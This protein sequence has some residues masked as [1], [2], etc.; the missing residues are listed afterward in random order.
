M[1]VRLNHVAVD[2]WQATYQLEV[3]V[4]QLTFLGDVKPF[5]SKGFQFA[6]T[7]FEVQEVHEKEVV[8]RKDGAKFSAFHF[9]F[10]LGSTVSEGAYPF[11]I[12]F[13]DGS[14]AL[15][16][17]YLSVVEDPAQ[18]SNA[19]FTFES[20]EEENIFVNGESNRTWSPVNEF[21]VAYVYFGS[22]IPRGRESLKMLSD[23]T[24]PTWLKKLSDK[25]L[26]EIFSFYEAEFSQKPKVFVITRT[27]DL[28]NKETSRLNGS[29]YPGWILLNAA[30]ADWKK[31]TREFRNR[32]VSL[33]AHEAMHRFQG[34][35]AGDFVQ[36]AWLIEGTAEFF[37]NQAL[38]KLGY[39]NRQEMLAELSDAANKCVIILGN[40]QM[41]LNKPSEGESFYGTY[42]CG[43]VL[44]YA[45]HR[46]LLSNT[47]EGLFSLWRKM[48]AYANDHNGNVDES[49]YFKVLNDFSVPP[50]YLELARR[51]ISTQ[52]EKPVDA[53][54]D[55][56]RAGGVK[57][58]LR[59]PKGKDEYYPQF[60]IL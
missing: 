39:S 33:V 56:L 4:T 9:N 50:N 36:R 7:D 11:S 52:H 26:P 37:K 38:A 14:A 19:V 41:T 32:F 8:K 3:P 47:A 46:R 40:N 58:K 54:A 16:T 31:P 18:S 30:G 21:D 5:R 35:P 48:L 59:K 17:G 22:L 10:K 27:Y 6:D 24:V 42:V 23:P 28:E 49:D 57:F 51:F 25:V 12:V 29:A 44:H 60:Q 43:Y 1:Q 2:E 13:S 15:H 45:T 55:L 34:R 20:L 53:V